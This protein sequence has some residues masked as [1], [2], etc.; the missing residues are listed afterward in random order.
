MPELE[1]SKAAAIDAW[2]KAGADWCKAKAA[3]YKADAAWDKACAAWDKA[4]D[5]Y[6]AEKIKELIN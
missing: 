5:A 6:T 3:R 2:Y 1:E 4:N